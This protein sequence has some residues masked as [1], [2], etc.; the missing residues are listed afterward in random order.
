MDTGN[1]KGVQKGRKKLESALVIYEAQ[2]K[3]RRNEKHNNPRLDDDFVESGDEAPKRKKL[4]TKNALDKENEKAKAKSKGKAPM[5]NEVS[6]ENEDG[7]M[8][9]NAGNE[10][11]AEDESFPSLPSRCNLI[12]FTKTLSKLNEKQ[13]NAIDEMGFQ[14][15]R[16]L[17]INTIP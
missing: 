14:A 2:N 5:F 1:S 3:R 9:V 7:D 15:V 12:T 11:D 13:V 16:D 17:N 8:N 4:V 6:E 10:E